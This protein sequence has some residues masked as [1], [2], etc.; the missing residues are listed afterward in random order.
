MSN[1]RAMSL[2]ALGLALTPLASAPAH[3]SPSG[4]ASAVDKALAAH[5]PNAQSEEVVECA[6]QITAEV[7]KRIKRDLCAYRSNGCAA[8]FRDFATRRDELTIA[9]E[10]AINERSVIAQVEVALF[11]LQTTL[12]FEEAGA[13]KERHDLETQLPR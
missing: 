12:D 3:A 1:R 10:S 7:D 2:F 4:Q 11:A 13:F 8:A 9:L 5:C 6:R